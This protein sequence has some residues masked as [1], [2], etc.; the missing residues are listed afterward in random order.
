[1]CSAH[2]YKA[3]KWALLVKAS[4]QWCASLLDVLDI[5]AVAPVP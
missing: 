1:M 2:V 4:F 5:V 3:K